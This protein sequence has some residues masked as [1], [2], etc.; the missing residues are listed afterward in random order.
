V[1]AAATDELEGFASCGFSLVKRDEIECDLDDLALLLFAAVGDA[2]GVS[3]IESL[4]R[5]LFGTNGYEWN[6]NDEA[7]EESCLSALQRSPK[8]D[9]LTR[10]CAFILTQGDRLCSCS[11]DPSD[12]RRWDGFQSTN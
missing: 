10:R 9:L 2:I 11:T 7:G 5:R 4:C 12:V 8:A 3:A 6:A 1:P